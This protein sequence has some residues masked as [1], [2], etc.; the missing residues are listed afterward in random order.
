[1][2]SLRYGG[3][4]RWRERDGS[5]IPPFASLEGEAAGGGTERIALV[6][7]SAPARAQSPM[8]AEPDRPPV[9]MIR[10]NDI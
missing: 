2:G 5:K 10:N 8:H 7:M 3:A 1:M 6:C 9:R 4:Y